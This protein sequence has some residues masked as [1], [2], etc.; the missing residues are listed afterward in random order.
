MRIGPLELTHMPGHTAGQVLIQVGDVLLCGDHILPEISPH[1]APERL[2]LNTGLGHYLASLARTRPMAGQVGLVLG[3]H[4]RPFND[5]AG[6]I[7]EIWALYRER[8]NRVI[9]MLDQPR[10][11]LEI[12][13]LIFGETAGYHHLLALEEA[14]AYV[15]YLLERGYLSSE[16]GRQE[17]GRDA[18]T[19]RYQRGDDE[20][21]TIPDALDT[22][23]GLAGAGSLKR[24]T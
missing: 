5:L 8:L 11:I 4:Q 19:I 9:S 14:G 10:T 17:D 6:R 13:D 22:A 20:G 12:A 16:L 18:G 7:D 24:R 1:I 2:S 15:E 3:G 21:H 23:V